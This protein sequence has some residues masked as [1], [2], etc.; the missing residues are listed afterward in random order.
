MKAIVMVVALLALI[1]FAYYFFIDTLSIADI[2]G[3]TGN[4][5]A[6]IFINLFDFDTGVTRYEMHQLQTKSP[7]WNRRMDEIS[8][9]SDPEVRQAENEKL[10]SEMM[11]D[12]SFKKLAQRLLGVGGK[13]AKSLLN[14]TTS[15]KTLGVF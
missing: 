8:R 10:V 14:I 13:T 7:E 15:F 6:D 12:P 1:G 5:T 11:R 3:S 4:N 2:I 9:I